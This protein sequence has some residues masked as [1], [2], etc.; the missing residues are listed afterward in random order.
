MNILF[1][2]G[3]R[4]VSGSLHVVESANQSWF[5]DCGL[6]Q[7]GRRDMYARNAYLPV[8][9][10]DVSAVFLTHAHVDHSGRLPR[11]VKQGFRGPIYATQATIDLCQLLLFDSAFVLKSQTTS[12]NKK[13]ERRGLP[14]LPDLYSGTDVE[15]TLRQMVP[16]KWNEK[17]NPAAELEVTFL[18]AGHILGAS[19][20]VLKENI[21]GITTTI[22]FSGDLGRKNEWIM[23]NPVVPEN[24]DVIV[25][26]STYGDREHRPYSYAKS[27]LCANL[28]STIDVGGRIVVPAFSVGRTQRMLYE[29]N[30]FIEKGAIKKVPIYLDS[31]LSIKASKLFLEYSREKATEITEQIDPYKLNCCKVV[32]AEESRKLVKTKGPYIVITASGM[33]EAGRILYHLKENLPDPS[34]RVIFCGFCA[35]NTLGRQL[36]DKQESVKILGDYIAVNA[37]ID[38]LDTF[39]AHADRNGIKSW[40]DKQKSASTVFIVHGEEKQSFSVAEKI[41]CECKKE[42]IIPLQGEK[43]ALAGKAVSSKQ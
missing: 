18:C 28:N 24:T 25:V 2:G 26:E 27:D 35:E 15:Q 34:S 16:V 14:P 10:K 13:R 42:I 9:A 7:G 12:L 6:F 39:S 4:T 23:P 3:A 37:Q 30:A 40:V 33:C 5:V 1:S 19:S 43:F 8:T 29:L 38:Y 22:A 41:E 11:L 20:I 31:P 17:I 32:S 36:I 21:K